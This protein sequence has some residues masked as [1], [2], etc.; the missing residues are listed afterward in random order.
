MEINFKAYIDIINLDT[1]ILE[2]M[3]IKL[4]TYA[5]IEHSM[6]K[7]KKREKFTIFLRLA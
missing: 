7:K 3:L 6:F 4:S 5:H 2:D 1:I